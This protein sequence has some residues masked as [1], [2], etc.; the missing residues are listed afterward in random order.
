MFV[1]FFFLKSFPKSLLSVVNDVGLHT[2][3]VG[4][5]KENRFVN[6]FVTGFH[7][8]KPNGYEIRSRAAKIHREN[9]PSSSRNCQTGRRY[10]TR[11]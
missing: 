2:K 8:R 4:D 6:E 7:G 10:K 11:K 5:K 1:F 3:V 9:D